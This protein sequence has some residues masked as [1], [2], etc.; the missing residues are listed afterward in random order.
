MILSLV[1][2]RTERKISIVMGLPSAERRYCLVKLY[3]LLMKSLVCQVG[4]TNI[5]VNHHSSNFFAAGIA[6]VGRLDDMVTF[7]SGIKVD[8]LSLERTLEALP[9]ISR[10][11]IILNPT[12]DGLTVL[13]DPSPAATFPA[14]IDSITR[15]NKGLPYEKRIQR[16]NIILV[17]SL[18]VTTKMTLHRKKLKRILADAGGQWPA[19]RRKLISTPIPIT[20]SVVSRPSNN[21]PTAPK[22]NI[23]IRRRM[24]QIIADIFSVGLDEVQDPGFTMSDLP[25][26]S[27]ASV[28]LANKIQST[29]NC[30]LTQAQLYSSRD[31]SDL[32][33]LVFD[34]TITAPASKPIPAPPPPII[35]PLVPTSNADHLIISGVSCRYPGGIM[36][37]DDLWSVLVSPQSHASTIGRQAP[38]SRWDADAL[39][40]KLPMA[41]LDDRVIDNVSSVASF[42][43][44]PP[45]EVEAM[46]PNIR[47]VMQMGYSALEDAGIAPSSLS[48]KP[49]GV[50]TSMNDSGWRENRIGRLGIHGK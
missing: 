22:I 26:T 46:P 39:E 41:W 45:A 33:S 34:S 1:S 14:I 11:A 13:I 40:A 3:L 4:H 48:G 16:E 27:L 19:D 43:R 18:P 49:W 10:C 2:Q 50:F 42:F 47:L 36:S 31:I 38:P 25:I 28:R 24:E 35:A 37:L 23:D 5:S 9:E 17:D 8:A 6:Y 29:F 20:H 21:V 15:V 32:C 12:Q 30:Q 44:L 7:N